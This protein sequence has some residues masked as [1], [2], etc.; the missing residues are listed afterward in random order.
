MHKGKTWGLLSWPGWQ[1][2]GKVRTSMTCKSSLP[3]TWERSQKTPESWV[4]R[5]VAF[6]CRLKWLL[7]VHFQ[8]SITSGNIDTFAHQPSTASLTCPYLVIKK[9]SGCCFLHLYLSGLLYWL[10]VKLVSTGSANPFKE[11][12]NPTVRIHLFVRSS[13]WVYYIS[14]SLCTGVIQR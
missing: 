9:L 2:R 12:S 6:Q 5:S 8:L 7:W 4:V 10:T 14:W 13:V 11:A 3:G 1:W